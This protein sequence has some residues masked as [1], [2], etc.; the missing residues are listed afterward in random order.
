MCFGK[1]YTFEARYVY[2]K[3]VHLYNQ[4]RLNKTSPI[5]ATVNIPTY[6]STPSAATLASL[7][8]T[9]GYLKSLPNNDLGAIRF[10]Q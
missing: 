3:G 1:D 7:P 8:Y 6:L 5:T 2:T 4:T 9:L 10:P